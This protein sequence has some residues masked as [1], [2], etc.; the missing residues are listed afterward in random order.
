MNWKNCERGTFLV[1]VL[2]IIFNQKT[3]K[4]LIGK[5]NNDPFFEEL[6][7]SFPGGRP[8][9]LEDLDFY[10]KLEIKKKTN[11]DVNVGKII[12]AKTYPENREFL[13]IYY[14]CKVT[15]GIE[16]ASEKFSEIKWVPINE[17]EK[18]FTTSLHPELLKYLKK[19]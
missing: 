2:G 9:Y 17:L 19:L 6:T 13:S 10:L 7:W 15:G 8:A 3:K 12:F 5:R 14:H 11:L 18:Y 16:K 4:I 1:N